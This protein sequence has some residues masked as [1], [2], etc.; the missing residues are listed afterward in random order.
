V[1]AEDHFPGADAMVAAYRE[2]IART[3]VSQSDYE[4]LLGQYGDLATVD[5]D[6]G[7][8]IISSAYGPGDAEK[9]LVAVI[10]RN[11]GTAILFPSRTYHKNFQVN[12]AGRS[13]A[14]Q[15]IVIAFDLDVDGTGSL[16]YQR[17]AIVRIR[18]DKGL[19]IVSK[20]RLGGYAG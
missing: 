17:P 6:D 19:E 20:G 9:K 16:S 8:L 4:T 1:R 10:A 14:G 7:H 5:L 2:L 12:F 3:V 15:E 13:Q 18:A 11:R